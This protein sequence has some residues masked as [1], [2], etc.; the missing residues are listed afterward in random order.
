MKHEN[1]LIVTTKEEWRKWLEENYQQT[2]PAWL[3]YF[4]KDSG[5]PTIS[6]D[7]SVEQALCFG[8]IDST[9]K[10]IDNEKYKRVF[11]PRTNNYNWSPSNQKR[12]EKLL[13]TNEMTVAGLN[14][15][16]DYAK[17]GKIEWQNKDSIHIENFS[18]D[19]LTLLKQDEL[20]FQNYSNMSPSHRQRYINWIMTAK[21]EETRLRR[22]NE[23]IQL[24]RA[25]HK[26]LIK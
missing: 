15:I 19:I 5:K 9:L 2:E 25:N 3:I 26:N 21:K 4:K 20:A 6:Y 1:E 24:L 17:T 10:S 12:V 14:K 11:M 22:L 8:W 16:G 23:A 13:A 7:D 18:E